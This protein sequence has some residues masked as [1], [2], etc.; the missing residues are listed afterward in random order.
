MIIN[1]APTDCYNATINC[2][3][4]EGCRYGNADLKYFKLMRCGLL[5]R[6]YN[7]RKQDMI[8]H[9]KEF[10]WSSNKDTATP[11]PLKNAKT[12]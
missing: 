4:Q 2:W 11:K 10:V 6:R 12:K 7:N 5:Q 3:G 8:P 1:E 9:T